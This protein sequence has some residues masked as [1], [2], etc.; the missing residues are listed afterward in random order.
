MMLTQ[1]A[2]PGIIIST[3][4]VTSLCIGW[5]ISGSR[6]EVDLDSV[7]VLGKC[8]SMCKIFSPKQN[9]Y[10]TLQSKVKYMSHWS[11]AEDHWSNYGQSSGLRLL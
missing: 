5:H 2:M 4:D 7:W 3:E 1:L 9:G 10:K 11:R 8:G 6:T